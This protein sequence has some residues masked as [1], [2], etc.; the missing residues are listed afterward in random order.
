MLPSQGNLLN[1]SVQ[2][3]SLPA[4]CS[5]QLIAHGCPDKCSIAGSGLGEWEHK[6]VVPVDFS[7]VNAFVMTN[8]KP[9]SN[10]NCLVKFLKIKLAF[11]SLYR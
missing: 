6:F 5:L 2:P 4:S 8:F 3:K 7:E 1:L 10:D 11:T 9:Q